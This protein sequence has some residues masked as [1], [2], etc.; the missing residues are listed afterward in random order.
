VINSLV[1]LKLIMIKTVFYTCLL[2]MFF[3]SCGSST[4]EQDTPTV[5]ITKKAAAAIS[6]SGRPFQAPEPS[7]SFIL[8]MKDAKTDYDADPMNADNIIWYGR[9]VAYLVDY[10][11]AIEIFTEGIQKHPQDARMYRHRGHRYISTRKFDL[12]IEDFKKAA[13]LIEGKENE[14]EPDG[15]PNAQNIPVSTL[16]GNIWYHLGLAYYLKHDWQNALDA[17]TKCRASGEKP[18]NIVSSTHW[19]YMIN[20]RM[21]QPEAAKVALTGIEKDMDIIENHSYHKLCLFYKGEISQ[22]ELVKTEGDA[23][24]NDAVLYGLAN[25]LFYN[26]NIEKSKDVLIEILKKDSWNSFGFIAAEADAVALGD[27]MIK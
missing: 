17:Y 26:D 11:K 5:T 16:H 21:N 24:A 13:S 18:D 3:L 22:E 12:A 8:K 4:T 19:I 14:V 2:F 27:E 15:L 20:R 23:P 9:R 1:S 10:K 25:W 6:L 7:P